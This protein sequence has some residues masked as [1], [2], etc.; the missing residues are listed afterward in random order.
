MLQ[1]GFFLLKFPLKVGREPFGQPHKSLYDRNLP[2][3][4]IT[5][6][7]ITVITTLESNASDLIF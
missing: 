4:S 7:K 5:D 1:N 2:L 3:W 6:Y